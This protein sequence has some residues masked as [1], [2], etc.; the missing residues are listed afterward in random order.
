MA[1]AHDPREALMIGHRTD[2]S[3]VRR[4]L[5]PHLQ[6]YDM[7]QMTS[8]LSIS[9]RATGVA[10]SLGALVMVWW[11]V[12]ASLGEGAFGAVQWFLGSFLGILFLMGLTATLWFHTLAGIRHLVWDAGH[13][14]DMP[15]V[16]RSGRAVLVGTAVLTAATWLLMLISW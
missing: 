2:G 11:L 8:A 16:Y 6:V 1:S 5:S 13:G 12:A 10:W 15:A 4:P 7:L 3:T 9:H 14:Y